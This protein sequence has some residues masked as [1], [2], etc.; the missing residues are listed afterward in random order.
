MQSLKITE[1]FQEA[2]TLLEEGKEHL[3]ITGKAGTGKSTLLQY[4][5]NHTK[6]QIVVLAPTGVAA[7]NVKGQTIHSF[8][9]FPSTT[10][11]AIK[12]KKRPLSFRKL[13]KKID[14][15]VIDEISMVRA[16]MLDLI[17]KTLRHNLGND[18]PFG[19]IRMV[20]FGDLYQ[21]PPVVRY[22]EKNLLEAFYRS[23]YFFEAHAL[24]HTELQIIELQ[25]IYRQT[26][27]EYIAL[28]NG[29]R[30][31]SITA[32]EIEQLNSRYEPDYEEA[33]ESNAIYL[34]T[35]NAGAD[36][37]NRKK[38]EE[39]T[40][41]PHTYTGTTTGNFMPSQA[42]A[43]QELELKVGA[44]VMMTSNDSQKRWVNGS[45][46]HI[47][48]IQEE[49]GSDTILVALSN[50]KEVEVSQYTWEVTH[51]TLDAKEQPT[52]EVVGSF[53]QYPLRL[54]WAVTIHKSQG[55]TFDEVI[56]DIGRGTFAH[57]QLY[58]ALSRCTSFEGMVLKKPVQKKHIWTDE[59]I[60]TFMERKS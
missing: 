25:T 18:S 36:A 14:A 15:I 49:E 22:E 57:G 30:G 6:K 40:S 43:A 3:F 28:L 27:G 54:A 39:L 7:L 35:T 20:F 21:L 24:H 26:E 47:T 60:Q 51:Y 44:Q 8:F 2:L 42:P 4:F 59:H 34:M 48:E 19:G 16:D 45:L 10:P 50:G 58:V 12:M 17:D 37:L 11:Q 52:S 1:E 29:I 13:L 53:T 32:E 46:G 9:Q 31:N 55:K 23:P 56:V 38:L 33:V 5:R 41:W